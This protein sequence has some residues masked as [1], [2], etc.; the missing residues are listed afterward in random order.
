MQDEK[1]L[2]NIEMMKNKALLRKT[3]APIYP[4]FFYL[5]ATL[6]ELTTLDVSK[7]VYPFILKPNIGFLVLASTQ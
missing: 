7:F 5:Q 4:E 6:Q 2:K 3:L 1:L